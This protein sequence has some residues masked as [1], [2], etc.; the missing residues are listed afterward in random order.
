MHKIFGR[1][2]AVFWSLVA[3]LVLALLQLIPMPTAV[4]GALNAVTLAA[5]GLVTAA[6][7]ATDK[8]LPALVGLIQAVFALFLALGTPVAE[9]TQTGILALVAAGAAFFVR[10]QVDAKVLPNGSTDSDPGDHYGGAHEV[11]TTM[12]AVDEGGHAR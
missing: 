10:G 7:V 5:A 8:V 3:G 9:T 4:N 2:P 6:M 11:T 12:P 1:E